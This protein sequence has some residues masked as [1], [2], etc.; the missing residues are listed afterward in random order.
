MFF[1]FNDTATTEIYPLSLHDAL[2]IAAR[3][4]SSSDP[5][6]KRDI[7]RVRDMRPAVSPIRAMPSFC[8]TR[9]STARAELSEPATRAMIPARRAWRMPTPRRSQYNVNPREIAAPTF[10][11]SRTP[12][13]SGA[14]TN[15]RKRPRDVRNT[16]APNAAANARAASP[17]YA[18]WLASKRARSPH[19]NQTPI[20]NT[21]AIAPMRR[22][23]MS[24]SHTTWRPRENESWPAGP[25]GGRKYPTYRKKKERKYKPIA[26]A[27]HPRPIRERELADNLYSPSRS[28]AQRRPE[29]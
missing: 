2:P 3:T 4:R 19:T 5:Q 14:Y 24:G 10:T 17:R 27:M 23:P 18:R 28:G 26:T 21:A 6:R 16:A 12:W 20:T 22:V 25:E 11:A 1:F 15:P 13:R 7:H 9:Q 8:V 29:R